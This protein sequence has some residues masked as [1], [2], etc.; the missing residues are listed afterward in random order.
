MYINIF[1]CIPEH[2]SYK[3]IASEAHSLYVII[4]QTMMSQA[5]KKQSKFVF[6]VD[7]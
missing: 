2:S 6:S 5:W 7:C 4:I 3:F 1:L